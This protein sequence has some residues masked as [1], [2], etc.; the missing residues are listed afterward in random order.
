MNAKTL[1]TD[2]CDFG[3]VANWRELG[4]LRSSYG[5]VG[6]SGGVVLGRGMG[7]MR[8]SRGRYNVSRACSKHVVDHHGRP[9]LS[10]LLL[11]G[12]GYQQPATNDFLTCTFTTQRRRINSRTSGP[13]CSSL[14]APIPGIAISAASSAGS[15]SAIAINVLSL[16]T[17]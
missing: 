7:G 17:T 2:P 6:R 12:K 4:S 10:N 16:K 11:E 13:Y 3:S 15:I 8:G 5:R 1:A 9:P 14:R